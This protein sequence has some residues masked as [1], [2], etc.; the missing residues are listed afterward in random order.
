M[1]P[2]KAVSIVAPLSGST[3]KT[4]KTTSTCQAIQASVKNCGILNKGNTFCIARFFYNQL[5]F[6]G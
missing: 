5:H 4:S 3:L 6:E 2:R 1:S